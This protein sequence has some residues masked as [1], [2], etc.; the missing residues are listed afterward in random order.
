MGSCRP[1]P[2]QGV[3]PEL[4]PGELPAELYSEA[5]SNEYLEAPYKL[6]AKQESTLRKLGWN[7]PGDVSSA[8]IVSATSPNWWRVFP[9]GS[10]DRF[11]EIAVAAQATLVEVYGHQGTLVITMAD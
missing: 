3:E 6:S 11:H 1:V 9:L 8:T 5:V 2:Q 10:D 4:P 7:D